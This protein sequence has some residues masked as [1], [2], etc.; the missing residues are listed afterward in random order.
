MIIVGVVIIVGVAVAHFPVS[1]AF[2]ALFLLSFS[3]LCLVAAF[4]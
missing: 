2:L 3:H 4:L 1:N